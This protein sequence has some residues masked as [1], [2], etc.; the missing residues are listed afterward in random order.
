MSLPDLLMSALTHDASVRTALCNEWRLGGDLEP[1]VKSA[2]VGA[3]RLRHFAK[4]QL[5]DR[6]RSGP[7][8]CSNRQLPGGARLRP[9]LIA[10]TSNSSDLPLG[11]QLKA[12]VR[13]TP[14]RR[15]GCAPAGG[16]FKVFKDVE[17]L[18]Q[19][20]GERSLES[21]V[22]MVA[23]VGWSEQDLRRLCR[24]SCGGYEYSVN[25]GWLEKGLRLHVVTI[26]VRQTRTGAPSRP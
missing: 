5:S 2:L 14:G 12:L 18:E 11:L 19:L 26:R 13:R 1:L 4:H 10:N 17:K 16:A 15:G 23:A 25:R 20:I 7:Y 9:D 6:Y 22:A 3:L 8:L 21:G 24:R